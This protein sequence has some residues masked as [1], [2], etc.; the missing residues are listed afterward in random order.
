MKKYLSLLI[1]LSLV[2]A[3]FAISVPKVS[4]E[5]PANDCTSTHTVVLHYHRWD[6]DYTN[7]DFWAWGT[8]TDGSGNPQIVGEDDFGAVAYLCVNDDS[9]AA[10]GLIPRLNDWSYKDGIDLNGDGG[11]DKSVTLKDESEDFVGFDEDGIKH[12]YILQG[13]AEV[14][15]NDPLMPTFQ[16]DGFGTLVVVY[17]EASEAYD[18]W[19]MWNWGTGTDG[20]TAGD[21]FG[22][23][24]VPFQ[25]DLGID[26]QA[27]P[28]KFKVA[29][30]NVAAD[31]DDTMGFIVR[32]DSWEKQWADDLFLD[33]SAIKGTGT[34]FT[35]YI[36]GNDAFYDNF[37]DFEAVVNF[38]EIAS[39]T[40]LDTTSV[41]IV[42]NKEIITE[43]ED[44]VVFDS[45]SITL[46][47]KDANAV[48]VNSTSF[49]S[50]TATND[51]FTLL[52]DSELS[53]ANSPY[54]VSYTVGEGEDMMVYT[55]EFSVD[56][57]APVVTIIGS[58][59]VT[60]ELGDTYS[61]PTYSASDKETSEDTESTVI[62]NVKVK[63]GHG[64]VDTRFAGVYEVVIVAED[65]FGNET[66]AMITVTVMD[67][68]DDTA[69]LD[70][71]NFNTEL[72]ALLVGIPLAF[73]AV[74]A[75]RRSY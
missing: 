19:N 45:A 57:L 4:A 36:G 26:Q 21:A 49:N 25:W 18:A 65:K 14:Y 16:K 74:V 23:S 33:I 9:D 58:R 24:G 1:T 75:L 66:E 48:V 8:G 31:A 71:N 56:S 63:D 43:V 50:T 64:T 6:E 10:A 54:T 62:Y 22:G 41:E 2:T 28:G 39:A 46:E 69:H 73:G 35:F 15:Y 68:C 40:A 52:L 60:L 59:N 47:D 29:V 32:T 61:L 44:V 38:F 53:G 37:T 3:F 67:P 55:K 42:F 30:F 11:D 17:Y 70:A 34:Q 12:V 27:E 13:S 5:V 51:T 20:T 7:M 72:I